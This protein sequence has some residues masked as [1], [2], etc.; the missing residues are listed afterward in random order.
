MSGISLKVKN[1][2]QFEARLKSQDK[3]V[4]RNVIGVINNISMNIRNTAV[5]SI[6]QNER[7]GGD[8]TRYNPK[9]TIRVSKAGDPPASD[10]GYLASQIIVKIDANQLGADIISNADYSEALEFG[11]LKMAARPFMQ[12]AAEDSRKKY[13]QKL[14]KAIKDGLK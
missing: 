8:S 9:R 5:K 7:A 11:T 4:H 2:K 1:M 10:T 14:T 12:P 6:L 3:G 13:E